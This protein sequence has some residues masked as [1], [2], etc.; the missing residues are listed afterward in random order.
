MLKQ[1]GKALLTSQMARRAAYIKQV[2]NRNDF[3]MFTLT[4]TKSA[5]AKSTNQIL[6]LKVA[7]KM[8]ACRKDIHPI[9]IQSSFNSN[10]NYLLHTATSLLHH[11]LA[12]YN[13]NHL[14]YNAATHRYIFLCG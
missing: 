9:I 4:K 8:K 1:N 6:V 5:D 12:I 14:N 13:G 2:N 3:L 11:L 7:L 10:S